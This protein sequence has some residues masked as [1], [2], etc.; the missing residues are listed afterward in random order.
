VREERILPRIQ[1][2]VLAQAKWRDPVRIGGVSRVGVI[3][4]AAEVGSAANRQNLEHVSVL[5]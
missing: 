2:I 3:D 5:L 1:P 4:E